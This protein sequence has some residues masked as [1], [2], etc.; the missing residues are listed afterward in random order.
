MRPVFGPRTLAFGERVRARA[1][2]TGTTLFSASPVLTETIAVAGFDFLIVDTEHTGLRVDSDAFRAIAL[3]GLLRDLPLMVRVAGAV[4]GPVQTALDAGAA[5]VM[6]SS[7]RTATDAAELLEL[8]RFAP[9][10]TRGACPVT[11]A[12][13]YFGDWAAYRDG[14]LAR[15]V[16]GCLIEDPEGI[17]NVDAIA[18]TGID[19]LWFGPFDYQVA[20]G[21]EREA[22]E[23]RAAASDAALSR[24]AEAARA[25]GI[26]FAAV[27]WNGEAA[28]G[29]LELG[30]SLIVVTSDLWMFHEH[31]VS[32]L[33][34]VRAAIVA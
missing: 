10:G 27:A 4:D 7:V 19:L 13:G 9:D 30:A 31:C 26:A 25:H 23:A 24:V 6:R 29:C 8:S 1:P 34:T 15:P 3:G 20:A 16:V 11:R 33:E 12:N 17:E 2:L 5:G 32:T 14:P 21:L 18:A 22:P 28:R